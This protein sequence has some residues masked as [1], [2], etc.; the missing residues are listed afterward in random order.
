VL[1]LDIV[2]WVQNSNGDP[3]AIVRDASGVQ[4]YVWGPD[5]ERIES[6]LDPQYQPQAVNA[7]G[8]SRGS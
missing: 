2:Q 1:A 7:T 3:I 8:R 5:V 6:G 4:W